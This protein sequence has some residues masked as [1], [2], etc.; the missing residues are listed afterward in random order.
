[1]KIVKITG[2]LYTQ[3]LQEFINCIVLDDVTAYP[4]YITSSGVL[5]SMPPEDFEYF[6]KVYVEQKVSLKQPELASEFSFNNCNNITINKG[7]AK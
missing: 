2:N 5:W 3:N 7:E 6:K 4:V 1:M